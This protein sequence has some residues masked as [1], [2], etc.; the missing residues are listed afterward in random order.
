MQV[1]YIF[2]NDLLYV[3]MMFVFIILIYY[4]Y[5]RGIKDFTFWIFSDSVLYGEQQVRYY[6]YII[7]ICF[8]NVIYFYN[9][10]IIFMM[11]VFI[12]TRCWLLYF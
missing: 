2:L 5:R 3:R 4:V 11:H 10:I 1:I 9:H 7:N 12:D 6:C 8:R